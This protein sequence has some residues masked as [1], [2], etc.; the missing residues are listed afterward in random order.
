MKK[1]L[2]IL[3]LFTSIALF[4]QR[5]DK[6]TTN[7]VQIQSPAFGI[8]TLK[9]RWWGYAGSKPYQKWTELATFFETKNRIDSF[10][11]K[12]LTTTGSSGAAT[13]VN[14][15]L[16]IPNYAGGGFF[17]ATSGLTGVGDSIKL[18][19][20]LNQ[21]TVI[22]TNKKYFRFLGGGENGQ[23]STLN[24][25]NVTLEQGLANCKYL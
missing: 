24:I 21:T 25:D 4:A 13:L 19:G 11:I 15:V 7:F 23:N 3:F 1:L 17:I 22:N 12:M 6:P 8:D 2:I 16:N 10:K 5:Q 20:Q 14:G 9:N 18:G